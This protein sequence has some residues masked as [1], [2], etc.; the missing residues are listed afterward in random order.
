MCSDTD[1]TTLQPVGSNGRALANRTARV[2]T[3]NAK[4]QK[5]KD[6]VLLF[7]FPEVRSSQHDG[8][9]HVQFSAATTRDGGLSWLLSIHL[10]RTTTQRLCLYQVG[11]KRT[12]SGAKESSR[13]TKFGSR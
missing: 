9:G 10:E 13:T 7:G 12:A 1:V 8:E 6:A 2:Q 5:E 11:R 4:K 3:A